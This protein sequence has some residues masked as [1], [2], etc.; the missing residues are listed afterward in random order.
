MTSGDVVGKGLLLAS[1]GGGRCCQ[2]PRC[3]GP[4]ALHVSSSSSSA[5]GRPGGWGPARH[6]QRPGSQAWGSGEVTRF[7]EAGST[8]RV[9]DSAE[10]NAEP[11]A[12]G[13]A[14]GCLP[15]VCPVGRAGFGEGPVREW[16]PQG[17]ESRR[18]RDPVSAGPWQVGSFV[19]FWQTTPRC[20]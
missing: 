13:G 17:S 19:P 8:G 1:L 5:G 12:A 2:T 10:S 15:G 6:R 4:L 16:C 9:G 14:L 11:A 20:R 7:P 3:T 18:R